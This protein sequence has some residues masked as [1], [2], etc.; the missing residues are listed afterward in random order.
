M[1][2]PGPPSAAAESSRSGLSYWPVQVA[3]CMPWQSFVFGLQCLFY[4]GDWKHE[5]DS[6]DPVLRG[7]KDGCRPSTRILVSFGMMAV[8]GMSSM[9][10]GSLGRAGGEPVWRW[11]HLCEA[12]WSTCRWCSGSRLIRVR[13]HTSLNDGIGRSSPGDWSDVPGYCPQGNIWQLRLAEVGRW[14]FAVSLVL[15]ENLQHLL[16]AV[17][18]KALI[19][20]WIPWHV[21]W[22]PFTGI[23]FL[24]SAVS[25]M[26]RCRRG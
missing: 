19:P 10:D 22:V 21:F 2:P 15:F 1:S 24:L 18:I 5:A 3:C 23:A 11:V 7:H 12:W 8:A 9:P 13:G 25:L 4:I 20:A 17:F 6:V 16:Y 14:M 26:T